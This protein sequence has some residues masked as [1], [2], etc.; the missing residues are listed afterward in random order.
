[1]RLQLVLMGIVGMV[2]AGGAGAY[3]LSRIGIHQGYS[4]EQPIAFP[5]KVHAG[6]RVGLRKLSL[7]EQ[8]KPG[9]FMSHS[10]Q[11]NGDR[12]PCKGLKAGLVQIGEPRLT[13][14]WK[15]VEELH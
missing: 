11:A 1:M 3:Q 12:P 5:H 8:G 13:D 6:D 14:Y 10:E 15:S 7:L 4:P 9:E 2:I